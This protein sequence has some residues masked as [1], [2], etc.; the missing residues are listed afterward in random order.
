MSQPSTDY[1]TTVHP[2]DVTPNVDV[3]AVRSADGETLIRWPLS[4]SAVP[5]Q[6][7][8]RIWHGPERH[9]GY[10]EGR[11]HVHEDDMRH[12]VAACLKMGWVDATRPSVPRS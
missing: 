10:V 1:P 7:R 3:P 5:G 9:G 4:M 6:H 2:R 11:T 12:E 8:I